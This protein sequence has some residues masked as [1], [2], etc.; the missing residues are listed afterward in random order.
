MLSSFSSETA[1][2]AYVVA[3]AVADEDVDVVVVESLLVRF[4]KAMSP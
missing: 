1:T 4:K 3:F 2:V